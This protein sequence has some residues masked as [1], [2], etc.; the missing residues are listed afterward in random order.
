[1]T[2]LD[3]IYRARRELENAT[4]C[5]PV[6]YGVRLAPD[7]LASLQRP[8]PSWFAETPED[9]YARAAIW[10]IP[11]IVDASLPCGTWEAAHDAE[12][13]RNWQEATP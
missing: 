12:T 8:A 7:V 5:R 10:G 13:W 1:M 11:C 6:I 4:P 9:R 2:L 3:A